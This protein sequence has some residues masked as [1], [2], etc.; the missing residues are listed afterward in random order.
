MNHDPSIVV[1]RK[2]LDTTYTQYDYDV[3]RAPCGQ[4]TGGGSTINEISTAVPEPGA[5]G[6]MVAARSRL[7]IGDDGVEV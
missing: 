7:G 5:L 3:S 2:G 4:T 6:M 1:W